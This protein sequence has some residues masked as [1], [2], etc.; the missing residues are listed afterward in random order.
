M[1]KVETAIETVSDILINCH[2]FDDALETL[3]YSIEFLSANT[4]I[5]EA[6]F[7][8]MLNHT[9]GSVKCLADYHGRITD[10]IE[11]LLEELEE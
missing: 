8:Q 10:D 3:S 7:I 6:E 11:K 9:F 4:T 5:E 2:S 1:K